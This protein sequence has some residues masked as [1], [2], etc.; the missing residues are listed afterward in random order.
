MDCFSAKLSADIL[1]DCKNLVTGGIES[2]VLLIP[3]S[4]VDKAA[5]TFD[6]ENHMLITDLVL[7]ADA[8]GYLWAGVKQ[9]NSYNSE[10]VP[11]DQTT[12]D[13]FRHTINGRVLNPSA[14][15]RLQVSHMAKDEHY[16]A[17]IE[18]KWKGE[19]SQDAF[20]VLGWDTGVKLTENTENP[21]ENDGAIMLTLA[22]LDEMLETEGPRILLD[23]DYD[24]TKT[25]FENKFSAAV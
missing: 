5:T 11:G 4:D 2:D 18:R 24:T 23:T 1:A 9:T 8:T 10:F 13:K 7:K 22:S 6:E 3:H 25:A 15:N 17:V 12:L 19:D 14:E 16:L 20:V 21:L